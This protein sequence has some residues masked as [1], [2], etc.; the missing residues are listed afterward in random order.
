[1]CCL[2]RQA[3]LWCWGAMAG[4]TTAWLCRS[5]CAWLQ[6]RVT[7]GYWWGKAVF[8]RRPLSVPSFAATA[9]VAGS[10]C[11]RATTPVGPMVTSVSSTTLPMEVPHPKK[12]PRP[13]L[14]ARGSCAKFRPVMLPISHWIRWVLSAWKTAKWSSSIPCL[15]MH[16]SCADSLT[17]TR[18]ESFSQAG[19]ACALMP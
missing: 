16:L 5:F 17:L 6:P 4:I 8:C 18:F 3:R 13:H 1:M 10:C 14:P 11:R 7:P 2:I 15:T 12:S 19:S 9:P